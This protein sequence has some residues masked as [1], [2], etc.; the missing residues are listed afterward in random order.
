LVNEGAV[1]SSLLQSG[2]I[3]PGG[4][5]TTLNN[6]TQQWDW[7]N[8]WAPLQWMLVEGLRTVQYASSSNATNFNLYNSSALAPGQDPPKHGCDIIK[9][10]S[11]AK[12]DEHGQDCTWCFPSGA[13]ISDAIGMHW[14]LS[15]Y[16]AFNRTGYMF[17]KYYAPKL[18]GTGA[19]GEYEVQ[20]GFGWTNGVVLEWLHRYGARSDFTLEGLLEK[21]YLYAQMAPF[22][23]IQVNPLLMHPP[24]QPADVPSDEENE[25]IVSTHI[26]EKQ[27]KRHAEDIAEAE[28]AERQRD[29]E[30]EAE[31]DDDTEDEQRRSSHD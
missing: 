13:V 22:A 20:K 12:C 28:R 1:V 26:V 3:M 29:Q 23:E 15:N 27:A 19:G 10:E 17:E 24:A 16:L 25:H 31:D 2:L 5:S 7:P 18:G 11:W 21:D 30:E 9:P 6:N 8:A 14:L 4:V